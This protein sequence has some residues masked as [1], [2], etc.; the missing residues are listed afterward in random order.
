MRV[1]FL[2]LSKGSKGA[3]DHYEVLKSVLFIPQKHWFIDTYSSALGYRICSNIDQ[4]ERP[5][6]EALS[7]EDHQQDGGAGNAVLFR[8]EVSG[9]ILG[10]AFFKKCFHSPEFRGT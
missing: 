10:A 5:L 2:E 9:P 6:I 7:Q 8:T 4:R 1:Y 3:D